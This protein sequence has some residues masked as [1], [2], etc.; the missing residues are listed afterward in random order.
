MGTHTEGLLYK[1]PTVTACLCGEAGV[2]SDDLMPSTLSLGR[3]DIEELTPTRIMD[4]FRE[5][6]VLHHVGDL[7][8]F[9]GNALIAF[10]VV[11]GDF[12]MMVS[13]LPF[14]LQMCLSG[15]LSGFAVASAPLLAAAHLPLLTS[16]CLLT[17]AK[18][19]WVRNCVAFAI[20]EKR[21]ESYVN[22]N[23]RM[24]ALSRF[25]VS[26]WLGLTDNEDIPMAVSTQ[27]EMSRP[28]CTFDRTMHLDLDGAAQLLGKRQMLPVRGKREIGLVLSQL[29]RMPT[30]GLLETRETASFTQFSHRKEAF[31]GL[32]QTIR[33]HLDRGSGYMLTPT[34]TK[35]SGQIVFH[36]ECARLLI[37]LFGGGQHFI[38]E[39][40]RR[41]QAPH[42]GFGLGFLRIEA[43]FKRSHGRHFAANELSC[44][45][46]MGS[47]RPASEAPTLFSSP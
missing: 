10:S 30:I 35:L 27:D 19:S 26:T 32:I 16:K 37:V 33:Q 42:E 2:H 9:D 4:T 3:E 44:Q 22:A 8:V 34:A 12:E 18:G 36:E 14:D 5:M 6:V 31:E 43:I 21:F 29:N 20:R 40:P 28:G 13:A 46:G 23:V 17:L 24:F 11:F 47:S 7:K 38:V 1:F 25:M 39:M 45:E 15:T 41:D